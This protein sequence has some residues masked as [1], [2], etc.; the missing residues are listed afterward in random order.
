MTPCPQKQ[1]ILW[2]PYMSNS[3]LQGDDSLRHVSC[4][5]CSD[6]LCVVL[7]LVGSYS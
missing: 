6:Q 4:V 5:M 3:V 1:V 2:Q 7:M